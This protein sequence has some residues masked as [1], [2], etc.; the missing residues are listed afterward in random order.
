MTKFH[1]AYPVDE[2]G[3]EY[4]EKLQILEYD[5]LYGDQ[6]AYG[7]AGAPAA[8]DLQMGVAPVELES[9]VLEYGRLLV[10]GENFTE[11]SAV[12]SGEEALGTVFVDAQHL[13]VSLDTTEAG[14]LSGDVCVAQLSPDGKE[15]SRTETCPVERWRAHQ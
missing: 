8:T 1:Q 14:E 6:S 3:E 5:M 15:L 7:N 4:L 12:V 11:F 10:T 2:C 13:A 9:A